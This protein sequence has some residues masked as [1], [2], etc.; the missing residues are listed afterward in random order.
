MDICDT[1]L[2]SHQQEGKLADVEAE[3]ID[4]GR[5]S[6]SVRQLWEYAKAGNLVI[7]GIFITLTSVNQVL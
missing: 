4:R 1:V 7:F 5:Y 3:A 6:G 2:Y